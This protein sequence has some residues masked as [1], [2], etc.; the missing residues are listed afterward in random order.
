MAPS[1]QERA[2][3][4]PTY[5]DLRTGEHRG[6]LPLQTQTVEVGLQT[7]PVRVPEDCRRRQVW[8]T[9]DALASSRS[10][11]IPRYMTWEEDSRATAIN[12]LDYYWDLVTWLFP[13]VPLIPLALEGVLEQ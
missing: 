6:N 11:Q 3:N 7:S 13:L 10:H 2:H 1:H 12:A 8:P 9:L 5:V 4:S